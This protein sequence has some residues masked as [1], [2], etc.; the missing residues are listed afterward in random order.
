MSATKTTKKTTKTVAKKQQKCANFAECQRFVRVLKAGNQ[1]SLCWSCR[2]KKNQADAAR[3][4][5][6]CGPCSAS[7]GKLVLKPNISGGRCAACRLRHLEVGV[8]GTCGEKLAVEKV[9][10]SGEAGEASLIC[11]SCSRRQHLAETGAVRLKV[12]I[13]RAQL[14]AGVTF[15]TQAACVDVFL[16]VRR[17]RGKKWSAW[18]ALVLFRFVLW[19][20][21]GIVCALLE[22]V[23]FSVS[24]AEVAQRIAKLGT[25]GALGAKK[26]ALVDNVNL[27]FLKAVREKV[28]ALGADPERIQCSAGSCSQRRRIAGFSLE[29]FQSAPLDYDA[30]KIVDRARRFLEDVHIPQKQPQDTCDATIARIIY[31]G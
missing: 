3:I 5:K 25:A 24:A 12:R 31:P 14:S 16:L 6:K 17:R 8:C 2:M 10:Q 4:E 19:R 9:A 27:R 1:G 13:P 11:E 29:G 15:A 26:I 7:A 30:V 20:R 23:A 22:P 21:F 28:R 18:C